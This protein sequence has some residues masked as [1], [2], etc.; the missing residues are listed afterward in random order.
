MSNDAFAVGFRAGLVK[1]AAASSLEDRVRDFQR[2]L[3]PG[4]IINTSP[5]KLRDIVSQVYKPISN[6]VQGTRYGHSAIYVGNG[7]II[8][9]RIGE[10]VTEKPLAAA[11][12]GN[13][14]VAVRVRQ[15]TS[16]ARRRAVAYARRNLG[17]DFSV[18]G[19][20]TGGLAPTA[21]AGVISDGKR[22]AREK[23]DAFFCSQL[24]ANAWHKVP[25]HADR[26]IGFTRP[27][28]I[29]KSEHV[30]HVA[31]LAMWRFLDKSRSQ[32]HSAVVNA[33]LLP[34]HFKEEKAQHTKAATRRRRRKIDFLRA[35]LMPSGMTPI[36]QQQEGPTPERVTLPAPTGA[37][38]MSGGA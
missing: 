38:P 21:V 19:L 3:R 11:A 14:M 28:D 25:F 17:K 30:E 37:A 2:H 7:K 16:D 23:L 9:A 5:R 36:G 32:R 6:L 22:K 4:D 27:V 15:A 24:V 8:E 13:K 18:G 34:T 10:G 26:G 20:V 31:K 35:G 1:A 29:L 12:A 33:L